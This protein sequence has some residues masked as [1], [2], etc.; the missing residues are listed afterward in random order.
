[1]ARRVFGAFFAHLAAVVPSLAFAQAWSVQ[2]GVIVR[3]EYDSNY[4]FAPDNA[5]SAF[6]TSLTPFVT[7]ARRTEASDVAALIAVGGNLV[8]GLSSATD[9]L[10]GRLALD[11]T[12]REAR[13][14]WTGNV[15]FSRSAML[16]TEAQNAGAVLGLA[17]TNAAGANGTYTYALTER[18]SLGAFA[19]AYS[20][21]YE[22][23]S[24]GTSFSDDHGYYAG[25]NAGYA[26]SDRTQLTA[27]AG[28]IYYSSDVSNSES[29]TATLGLVHQFSPRL[30]ISISAGGFSIDTTAT[31]GTLTGNRRPRHG[32]ALWRSGPLRLLRKFRDCH[33]SCREP[34]PE[35]RRCSQQERPGRRLALLPGHRSP[36][37]SAGS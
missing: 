2:S 8:S 3:G 7:A 23:V 22:G 18:W 9:Y 16:Q 27:T 26:F 32:R 24:G 30:K 33:K 11:G 5:Q 19:S 29:V 6:T 28:Y 36:Y 37:G 21:R 15:A 14:T 31:Q 4:F 12:L 17:Y 25:G 13:S 20:N 10:S 1:M 34:R 35:R